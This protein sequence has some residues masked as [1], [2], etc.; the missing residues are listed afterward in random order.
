MSVWPI[1][2]LISLG[3][4]LNVLSVTS[5][6]LRLRRLQK[7]RSEKRATATVIL[8]ITGFSPNLETLIGALNAQTLQPRRLII[9]VESQ[10]DPAWR[11]A[12]AMA[13]LARFPIEVVV[14][15]EASHQAQKCRNQ[16]AALARIDAK[17]DA[18]VLMDNDIVP[19]SWWL[20]ALVSPLRD[21]HSD[22]VTGHRWQ[23]VERHRLGAH[24]VAAIDRALTLMP[25]PGWAS[26][27]VVWGGSVGISR[28]AA[29]RMDLAG[30]LERTL[31]DDL[32][33]AEHAE[34]A[35]LR[36]LTRGALL[37]PS[38]TALDLPSAWRFAVRQYRIGH[39]Y[40][41]WLW[42][43]AVLCIGL[44]LAAWVAA[45]FLILNGNMFAVWAAI[46]M[47][48]LA[49][50]KQYLVGEVARGIDM[51]DPLP[52]R[53][54]QLA[55]GLAQPLADMFHFAVLVAAASTRRVTWGHVTYEIAGPYAVE[56]KER[57]PFSAS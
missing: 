7:P 9:T 21:G 10:L 49:I 25:R 27:S 35:G 31:S 18:I 36:T 30:S 41:P 2:L 3:L 15:G 16:Q 28:D 12:T 47:A 42:R 4:V 38:P 26:T 45:F 6:V 22:L 37:I 48:A 17:D 39:I 54:A 11:R 53:A 8:P 56:V 33:L 50:L 34:A 32:S 13:S 5:V 29:R 19:Q 14:A 55:L 46:A 20:S 43:L 57:L 52:V 44:R 24:L 23:R 51:P 40:R 1:Y